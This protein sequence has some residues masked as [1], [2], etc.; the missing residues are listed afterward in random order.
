VSS[1]YEVRQRVLRERLAD[2]LARA[3][4]CQD[5]EC[6]R[7]AAFG[8]ALLE[9]HEVDGRGGAGSVRGDGGGEGTDALC[10]RW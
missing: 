4:E 1:V 3:K 8:L 9:R 2:I 10:W 6:G 5:E 7:L